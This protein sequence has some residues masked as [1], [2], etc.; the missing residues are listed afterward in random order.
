MCRR[1]ALSAQCSWVGRARSWERE[2]W[3]AVELSSLDTGSCPTSPESAGPSWSWTKWKSIVIMCWKSKA[4]QAHRS[5][6]VQRGTVALGVFP[7]DVTL[8]F[9]ALFFPLGMKMSAP[10]HYLSEVLNVLV[11]LLRFFSTFLFYSLETLNVWSELRLLIFWK[12]FS[13]PKLTTV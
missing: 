2:D 5:P 13:T 10:C 7:A 9:C 3:V 1:V 11:L 6:D 4:P 12:H 8:P